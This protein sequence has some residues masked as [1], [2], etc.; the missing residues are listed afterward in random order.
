MQAASDDPG[1]S[2]VDFLFDPARQ[3]TRLA[4]RPNFL[5]PVLVLTLGTLALTVAYFSRLDYAWF[6]QHV[7]AAN[8]IVARA[9][10]G[11]D[12]H[13]TKALLMWPGVLSAVGA[14]P[15]QWLL[16]S[17][18]VLFAASALRRPMALPQALALTAWA[19]I[20]YIVALLPAA[21][22]LALHADGHLPPEQVDPTTFGAM[23]GAPEAAPL[24]GVAMRVGLAS[25]W[26]WGLFAVGLRV[27]L[28]LRW[29]VAGALVAVPVVLVVGGSA[30]LAAIAG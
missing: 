30:A 23:F 12:L 2:A 21:I 3:F 22:N 15:V 14:V 8:P 5:A 10:H 1:F 28:S 25:L 16:L 4:A 24:R 20:P 17:L 29:P 6:A 18:Y 13:L 9:T 26:A 11:A 27:T 19:G 7:V